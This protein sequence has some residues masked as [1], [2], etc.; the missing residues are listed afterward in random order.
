MPTL[1][2]TRLSAAL[3][4]MLLTAAAHATPVWIT[5]G[6]T[7]FRQLQR[8]DAT[9]TAQYSTTVDAGKAAD[10]AAR[11]ETVHVVEIDD[12][13]LGE[14]A[15]AVQ[16]TR[17]HGPGYV[18]HDSFDDARQALQPLPATLAKQAAAA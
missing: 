12:S 4:G 17:G 10:G 16:R 13:R 5:L 9:A 7:A 14:L 1:K 18:V 6:D 11:R 8:I 2:P 15:R 3:G